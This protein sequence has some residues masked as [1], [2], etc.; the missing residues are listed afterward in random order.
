[1]DVGFDGVGLRWVGEVVWLRVVMHEGVVVFLA[2]DIS[3][4]E[5]FHAVKSQQNTS[6]FPK[7][8]AHRA[9]RERKNID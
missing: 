2:L 5:N 4:R 7:R 3:S 8:V 6:R 9:K 1:M